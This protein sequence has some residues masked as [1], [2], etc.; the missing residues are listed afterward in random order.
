MFKFKL[1]EREDAANKGL[2]GKLY[3][4]PIYQGVMDMLEVAREISG[5]STTIYIVK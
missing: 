2:G 3:A 1:I 4:T 5:R